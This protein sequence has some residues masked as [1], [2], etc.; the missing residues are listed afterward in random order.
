MSYMLGAYPVTDASVLVLEPPVDNRDRR[1]SGEGEGRSS[2]RMRQDGKCFS[3]L[4]YS[5]ELW[6]VVK[7]C[8]AEENTE[9]RGGWR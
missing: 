8:S 3:V 4:E 1:G 7:D 9:A 5:R 2:T 6:H